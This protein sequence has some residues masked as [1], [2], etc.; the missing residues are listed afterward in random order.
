MTAHRIA[1][2]TAWIAAAFFAVG[3]GWALVDPRS[4]FDIVA[5]YPPYNA[6][7]FHDLGS[8]QLGLAAAVVAGLAG[9]RPLS[10]GLWAATVGAALHAVSHWLD[11]DLGGRSTDPILLTLLAAVLAG[12]LF[13]S[14][15]NAAPGERIDRR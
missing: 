4:F 10:V 9:R 12:G 14:E 15:R 13:V 11:A 7:L 1:I 8:F 5:H 2:V 3:G 6:H